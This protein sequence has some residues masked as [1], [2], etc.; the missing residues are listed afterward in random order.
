MEIKRNQNKSF[1]E[2]CGEPL[3]VGKHAV[4]QEEAERL[5]KEKCPKCDTNT[6]V[7]CVHGLGDFFY[8]CEKCGEKWKSSC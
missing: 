4:S 5:P 7:V 3:G 1:C 6:L 2:Y 8:I